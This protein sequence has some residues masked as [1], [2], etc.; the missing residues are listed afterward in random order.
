MNVP[1]GS[2]V[3]GKT[4]QRCNLHYIHK[5]FIALALHD[6]VN[7]ALS[8][9]TVSLIPGLQ[10]NVYIVITCWGMFTTPFA[11]STGPSYSETVPHL[12]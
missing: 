9:L 10:P 2:A 6:D 7:L 12:R 3:G 8:N 5:Q 4:P 11:G 1:V